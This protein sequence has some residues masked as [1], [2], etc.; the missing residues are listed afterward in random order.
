MSGRSA[1]SSSE[2]AVIRELLREVRRADRSQQKAIRAKM[3][4]LGF[5]ITD[6]ATDQQG[7]TASDLD[8]LIA[9][10]TITVTKG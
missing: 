4:R 2:I 3:R 10:G 6:Y 9:R 8:E 1:F 5:F 7:F